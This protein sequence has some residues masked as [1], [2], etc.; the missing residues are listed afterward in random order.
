MKNMGSSAMLTNE[1]ILIAPFAYRLHSGLDES[2]NI[3]TT[4]SPVRYMPVNYLISIMPGES[5][6][7][8]RSDSNFGTSFLISS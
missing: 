5:G 8:A 7:E 1:K 6:G 4:E 3:S 2:Q